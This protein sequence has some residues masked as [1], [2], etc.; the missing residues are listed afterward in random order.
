MKLKRLTGLVTALM[1]TV[2]GIGIPVSAE[3]PDVNEED[4]AYLFAYFRD[5]REEALCYGVSRDGYSFR[6]LNGG[7]P[8]FYSTEGTQHLRDPFIFEGQDGYFYIVVTDMDS[9]KGWA[10]QSTIA[11]YKTADLINIDDSILIDYKQFTGFEDCNRAWAPQIIWCP[12]HDNG[13][14]TTGAYMIYLALQNESTA[15]SVGTVMYKHFA[16]DLMDEST[17]TEP[18]N[19]ISGQ[20]DGKYAGIG[21]IDG[22]ITY[23]PANDRYIMYFDGVRVA[24]SDT[25]DGEYTELSEEGDGIY[26]GL[27]PF[28]DLR[29]EGS[30]IFKLNKNGTQT[31]D[32]WIYC[33]DGDAFGT[34]YLVFETTDFENYTQIGG[35]GAAEQKIDYDFTPR[36]GYVIP[37]SESEL[38]R[39]FE[40][41]GWDWA[42]HAFREWQGWSVEHSDDPGNMAPVEMTARKQA[43]LDGFKRNQEKEK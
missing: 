12:E 24:A 10:S 5:N 21:A 33:A 36:H 42:Y 35:K 22:D 41:Y 37:I 4:T 18:Q 23:D 6:A 25:V 1:L 17:Y 19:M 8:V 15:G 31:E 28:A 14:G 38:N 34:G 30:N 20:Q 3:P 16:T 39:L 2:T 29:S 9:S 13:Y 32:K 43:I 40:E 11:I 7:E 26:N 27:S